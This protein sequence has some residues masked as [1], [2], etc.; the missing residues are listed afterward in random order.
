MH[1]TTAPRRDGVFDIASDDDESY[2]DL[3]RGNWAFQRYYHRANTASQCRNCL[4]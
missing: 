3:K 2:V 4:I 1:C